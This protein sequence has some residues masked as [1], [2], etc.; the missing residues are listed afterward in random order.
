LKAGVWFRRGLLLIVSPVRG[1]YRRYQAETPLIDLFKF[2]SP[3][4]QVTASLAAARASKEPRRS[5]SRHASCCGEEEFPMYPI[6]H[7]IDQAHNKIIS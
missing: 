4:L 6:Y 7:A 1:Y 2:A 3:A 5:F